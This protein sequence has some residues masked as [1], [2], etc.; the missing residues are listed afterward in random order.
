MVVETTMKMVRYVGD[1]TAKLHLGKG[2]GN[3]NI[4]R[5]EEPVEESKNDD[6]NA[7]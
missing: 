7:T 2:K 5:T 4:K 6:V 3:T 1:E